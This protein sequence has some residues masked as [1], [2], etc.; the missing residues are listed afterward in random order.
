MQSYIMGRYFQDTNNAYFLITKKILGIISNYQ[1]LDTKAP[2]KDLKLLRL[3]DLYTYKCS[4]FIY[5]Y[6]KATISST[7]CTSFKLYLHS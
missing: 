1:Q 2:F 6:H 3:S 4:L 7:F 5:K